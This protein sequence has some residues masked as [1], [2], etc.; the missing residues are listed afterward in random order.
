MSI[1]KYPRTFHLPT[2]KTLSADDKRVAPET[3]EYLQS[4]IELISTEKLDGSNFNLTRNRAFARS[5]DGTNHPW[6][7]YAR[8]IWTRIRWDLPENIRL[9]GESL[10]GRRSVDYDDLPSPFML[11]A[12]WEDDRLLSWD[13]MTEWAELL[14]LHTVPLLYRGTDF[15]EATA[16]W[17]KNH[18]EDTSEGFVIRDAGSFHYD[19]F[20]TH[21][22]KWVRENHVRTDDSFR[23]RND[24]ALNTFQSLE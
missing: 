9:S 15:N 23:R 3:L 22:A 19:D 16:A 11:F 10:Q 17:E 2:S 4:G 21:V 12:V 14:N 8:R 1:R 13:E 18:D 6:D 7:A 24:F 5:V 20:Q